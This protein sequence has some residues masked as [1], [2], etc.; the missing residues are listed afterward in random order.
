MARYFEDNNSKKVQV[1]AALDLLH[2]SYNPTVAASS[3]ATITKAQ[4]CCNDT[5]VERE[6][7]L[8]YTNILSPCR[9]TFCFT[10]DPK[11]SPWQASMADDVGRFLQAPRLPPLPIDMDE[12]GDAVPLMGLSQRINSI[13]STTQSLSDVDAAARDEREAES[14]VL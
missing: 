2:K 11:Y 13:P 10:H 3:S 9:R 8:F 14:S 7:P 1:C 5:R 6:L 4:P 12:S